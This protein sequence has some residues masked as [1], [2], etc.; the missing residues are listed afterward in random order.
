MSIV[1]LFWSTSDVVCI[2]L[3]LFIV[4]IYAPTGP[5]TRDFDDVRR[6]QEAAEKGVKRCAL[7]IEIFSK[8]SLANLIRE[9]S[10]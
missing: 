1:I 4:Q 3:C 9:I 8:A 6:F 10:E 2:A 7:G 5:V